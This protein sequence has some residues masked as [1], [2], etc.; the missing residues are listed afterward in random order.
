VQKLTRSRKRER[1]ALDFLCLSLLALLAPVLH[2][3]AENPILENA[4]LHPGDFEANYA[5][6]EYLIGTKDLPDAIPYLEKAWKINPANYTNGYD[7]ALTYL[8]T[9]APQKSRAVIQDLIERQNRAELHNLLADVEEAEGRVNEAAREYETAARMDPSE[10]NVFDL[11]SD[12]LKHNA[13]SPALKVFEFGAGRYK[14]S[15]RIRVGLGIAYYSVGRY[16]EA[17]QTLCK[18]VDLDPKDT[19]ALDFLGKMYDVSPRYADEV[20]KRLARFAAIYPDNSAANYYYALSLRK[21]VSSTDAHSTDKEV[22]AHLIKAVQLK[23]NFAAGH[24]ELGLLYEDQKRDSDAIRQYELAIKYEP[25]LV[26]AHYHLARL[27]RKSGQNMLA[28]RESDTVKS[29]KEK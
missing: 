5:A 12:L 7:L 1:A 22:E 19:K 14:A 23:P 8:E 26:K 24:F 21:R 3:G 16:D 28:Q 2:K 25:N 6:G 10:K 11:G 29:L 9:G 13:F 27:Y 15:A 4:R 17:V 20:T 18:A